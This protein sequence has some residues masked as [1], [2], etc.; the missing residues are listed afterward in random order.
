MV[1]VVAY[2]SSVLL[3][4]AGAW[5]VSRFALRYHLIDV[6]TD[7]SS[8]SVSTP[9][10][11]GV[12][13]LAAFVLASALLGISPRIWMPAAVVS[14]VSFYGDRYGLSPKLRLF[15]QFIVAALFLYMAGLQP[16]S[17][18]HV[19]VCLFLLLFVVGTANFYNFMDGINGIAGITGVIGFGFLAFYSFQWGGDALLTALALC[20]S[21]SCL[22]FLPFNIPGARVFMGDVGSVLLGFIFAQMVVLLSKSLLDFVCLISFIFPFYADEIITMWLRLKSRDD[23]VI[24]HR[25]HLYQILANEW[26]ISHWKI[27]TG[28]GL[29]QLVVGSSVL[30]LRPFGAISVL[31]LLAVCLCGFILTSFMFRRRFLT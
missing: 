14:L 13:I 18:P 31:L 5:V 25:R 16:E 9:K 10:G 21:L 17:L 20:V 28:Y 22:G 19:A 26:G 7:R 1:K 15:V 24:P 2:I 6:P 4:G 8:H 3:S 30:I 23:L 12:G 29:F 11:G 27:S